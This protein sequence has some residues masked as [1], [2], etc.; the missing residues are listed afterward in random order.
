MEQQKKYEGGDIIP[1]ERG[2]KIREEKI[3]KLKDQVLHR[4]ENLKALQDNLHFKQDKE[5]KK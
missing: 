4:I 5:V 3:E 1:L 2:F